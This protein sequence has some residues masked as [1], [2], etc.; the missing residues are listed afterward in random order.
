MIS[1]LDLKKINE[2]YETAFQEKLKLVLDNGW[3]VLGNEVK[4][5]ETSFANYCGTEYCV[6]VGNGFDALVLIFKGYIQLGKLQKGDEVIVPANTYIASILAIL[7]ADLIPVLVEP[8][9]ETYNINP[10]L[11]V[12]KI[13]SKTK[14]ILVVHLYGQ[15]AEMDAIHKIAVANDLLVVEDAAQ[16][17]GASFEEESSN[18]RNLEP[19]TQAYS[20]YPGKN[21]GTLGDAGAV[22]TNDLELAKVIQSLRNY[23]SETKY[24]NDYIG[25]NSRL[26]ELQAAFLN[27]KLPFLD[28]ENEKRRTIAK[29]YLSEIKNE[30]ITLPFWDL[31]NNHVFHL[32][33]IRTQNRTQFQEYLQ[34]NGIQ[35]VIHYPVPPHNQ[36]ALSPE[37][38]GWNHLSFPITEKIHDEVL[39]LPISPVLTD[40]EV[41]FVVKIVNQWMF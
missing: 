16:A 3:Y 25:V 22:T 13:T 41:G 24:Y 28:A 2:P 12:E 4:E 21:L 1:F 8:K 17:H 9:L 37:T 11:I 7:Q 15:L 23:G 6:G 26:D 19:K 40:D 5:F 14:A 32:F 29:R 18:T 36:K 31:S 35:T 20:F 10:D 34:Q 30:K 33:V 39:S 27:V 38:S